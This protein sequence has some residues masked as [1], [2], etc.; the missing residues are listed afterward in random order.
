MTRKGRPPCPGDPWAFLSP[1]PV[2][3]PLPG[4]AAAQQGL[5]ALP[6]LPS[7]APSQGWCGQ[8]RSQHASP[9]TS[10]QQTFHPAG[11]GPAEQDWGSPRVLPR[12]VQ[13]P[14]G[15]A[16]GPL[17]LPKALQCHFMPSSWHLCLR[18]G[19]DRHRGWLGAGIPPWAGSWGA[20][21]RA[22]NAPEPCTLWDVLERG[23]GE[24]GA[25]LPLPQTFPFPKRFPF[26]FPTPA[27]G[28]ASP[29]AQGHH[30]PSPCVP[31]SP[32]LV[33]GGSSVPALLPPAPGGPTEPLPAATPVQF[34]FIIPSSHS[35][36]VH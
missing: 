5:P 6:W 12:G 20:P 18:Q 10:L 4:L 17:P 28:R 23:Q 35:R 33:L 27:P 7:L 36:E 19:W 8:S 3:V 1:S 34:P 11:L 30:P 2:F 15:W 24:H 14:P 26:S 16:P 22:S 31:L 32:P 25:S 13:P 29:G 21:G 9:Q